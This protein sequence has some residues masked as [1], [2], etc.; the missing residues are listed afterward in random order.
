VIVWVIKDEIASGM[1]SGVLATIRCSNL[2]GGVEGVTE[3]GRTAYRHRLFLA[4]FGGIDIAALNI[5]F[6]AMR[7]DR[8]CLQTRST[9]SESA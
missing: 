3:I 8:I 2:G 1:F 4:M 5:R 9:L 7:L 6:S